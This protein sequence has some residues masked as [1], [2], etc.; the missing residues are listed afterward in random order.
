MYTKIQTSIK[1]NGN[2]GSSIAIAT[3]LEKEDLLHESA[4]L[5]V[6][7]IPEKRSG[8]FNH[9]SD[10]IY[11][12]DV[13][14]AI[15]NNKKALGK[16]DS[17]F[18]CITLAPT[19][20]EQMHLLSQITNHQ[21][22]SV[23]KLTRKQF[24]LFEGKLKEYA[25]SVM[26]E[27]AKNFKREGL[28]R[29]DQLIYFGKIEHKRQY[30]GTDKLVKDGKIKSGEYKPGLQSHVH[31]IVSRK[32]K[33]QKFKL[34]PLAHERAGKANS[35]LNG[36]KVQRG[37][38]RVAF[39]ISTEQIFDKHFNYNRKPHQKVNNMINNKKIMKAKHQ[40]SNS[41]INHLEGFVTTSKENR[42]RNF[43]KQY[44]GLKSGQQKTEFI[45]ANSDLLRQL[46]IQRRVNP[47]I[48]KKIQKEH[49]NESL[50]DLHL[51]EV[52]NMSQE[53]SLRN[54]LIEKQFQRD[55]IDP[56]GEFEIS[57]YTNEELKGI[58]DK[59][60]KIFE[61]SISNDKGLEL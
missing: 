3:Y 22:D 16:K 37:F 4:S 11:K 8:F 34:S 55:E 39:K 54:D 52:K 13:V 50:M 58:L 21:I 51:Q 23:E 15:D 38:D 40:K 61:K 43:V 60:A 33:A 6:N 31:I 26:N 32:D 59:E 35:K 12:T 44:K 41:K 19:K 9:N 45:K 53:Q 25:N 5:K 36:S 57:D 7:E 47:Q 14:E 20:S 56:K 49:A 27:Y 42:K 18:Y 46:F 17:K 28:N 29:G 30:K 10:G 1:A 48:Q 2:K 24:D